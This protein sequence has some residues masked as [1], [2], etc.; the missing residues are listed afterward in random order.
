[1]KEDKKSKKPDEKE[2]LAAL[3]AMMSRTQ[4]KMPYK[5]ACILNGNEQPIILTSNDKFDVHQINLGKQSMSVP[6]KM[7]P[8]LVDALATL[9]TKN[10]IDHFGDDKAFTEFNDKV[11]DDNDITYFD[12][13]DCEKGCGNPD[14]EA[15]SGEEDPAE[16]IMDQI[17]EQME[18]LGAKKSEIHKLPPEEAA[19][20]FKELADAKEVAEETLEK[21]ESGMLSPE[22]ME[23]LKKESLQKM[24]AHFD[25]VEGILEGKKAKS[26]EDID[27]AHI[28]KTFEKYGPQA[29]NEELLRIPAEKRDEILSQMI[30]MFNSKK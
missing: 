19:E 2:V 21:L 25:E 26:E 20:L 23:E 4:K 17:D 1:M 5:S 29:A 14:C 6:T 3:I 7:I 12:L 9:Y 27:F 16:E 10:G 28:K 11:I 8:Y 15:C 13:K 18:N 24:K 30:D 22:Q